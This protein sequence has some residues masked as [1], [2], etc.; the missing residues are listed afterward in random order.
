[1][2]VDIDDLVYR[3]IDGSDG[4]IALQGLPVCPLVGLFIE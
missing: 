2:L 4:D 1:M 3:I